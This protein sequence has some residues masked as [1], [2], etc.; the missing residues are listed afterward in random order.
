[1]TRT[2]WTVICTTILATA[3]VAAQTAQPPQA[4]TSTDQQRITVTGCLKQVPASAPATTTGTPGTTGATGTAGTPAT[5][6]TSGST[7]SDAPIFLL[8]NATTSS[9]A[10]AAGTAG[11]PG[12]PSATGTTGTAG[13]P[14]QA[15]ASATQTYRLI[16]SAAALTPHV[17]KK[18][19]V[20]GTLEPPTG[21]AQTS[22][23][24]TGQASAESAAN[25]RALRVESGK[26]IAASCEPR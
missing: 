5:T 8:T 21:S 1:M 24:Q 20:T 7:A 3:I 22:Q 23:A 25:A 4:G 13:A 9:S 26:V 10:G 15:D 2:I 18:L 11:A 19:E 16:A 6:G 17:G 14:G 12:T